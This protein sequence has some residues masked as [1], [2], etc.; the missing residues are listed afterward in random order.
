MKKSLKFLPVFVLLLAATLFFTQSAFKQTQKRALQTFYYNGPNLSST[1]V[2]K[3]SNW[4]Y[5]SG[6]NICSGINDQA[7]TIQVDPSFVN[8]G[9]NTLKSNIN[10]TT[11]N[12]P[13]PLIT[14]YVTGSADTDMQIYNAE[15][16]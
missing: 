13:A 5:D 16:P 7:C 2:A 10:L 12:S 14:A 9:S 1:E 11:A 8:S 3:P 4:V 15:H 6:A